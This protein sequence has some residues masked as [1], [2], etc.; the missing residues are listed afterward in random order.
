RRTRAT[1]CSS[2]WTCSRRSGESSASGDAVKASPRTAFVDFFSTYTKDL[3]ADDLQRLFTRDAREAYKFF[4]RGIQT[5]AF[6][7][8]PWYTRLIAETRVL[9]LAFTMKLS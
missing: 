6:K 5:D 1:S 2:R 8:L 4:T 3:T 9:F 7:A